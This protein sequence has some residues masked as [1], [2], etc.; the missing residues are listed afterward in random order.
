MTEAEAI[1]FFCGR[2]AADAR[3]MS[4]AEA[5]PFL[6]GLLSLTEGAEEVEPV[7]IVYRELCVVDEQ[8]ELI[9]SGRLMQAPLNFP[10][11]RGAPTRPIHHE[12]QGGPSL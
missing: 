1:A 3:S 10:P 11:H 12:P 5:R 4:L 6:R 9:A 2:V 8:L 7:R